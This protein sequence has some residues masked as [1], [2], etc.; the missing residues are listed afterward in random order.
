MGPEAPTSSVPPPVGLRAG[1]LTYLCVFTWG[2]DTG[3]ALP[4]S[5]CFLLMFLCTYVLANSLF[6]AHSLNMKPSEDSSGAPRVTSPGCAQELTT[7]LTLT[8]HFW[9]KGTKVQ[10]I[11]L[12]MGNNSAV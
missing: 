5:P 2:V 12:K 9:G 4:R 10:H 3:S 7:L 6:T 8:D 1:E 11:S